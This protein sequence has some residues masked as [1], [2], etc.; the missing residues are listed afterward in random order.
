[1]KKTTMK[2]ILKE[3]SN[4][5]AIKSFMA[6]ISVHIGDRYDKNTKRGVL[7]HLANEL[8]QLIST[9]TGQDV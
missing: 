2:T 7:K 9:I 4:D 8:K 5:A 6:K 1:M 3:N